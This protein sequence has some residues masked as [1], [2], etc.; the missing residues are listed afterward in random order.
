[1]TALLLGMAG[2]RAATSAHVVRGVIT[3]VRPRDIAHADSIQLR[4][5]SGQVISLKVADSVAFPPSH[6]RE[7]ML[8]AEPVT[9]TYADGPDGAVAT[10]V[11]D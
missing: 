5:E 11:T 7:H 10:E 1:V 3:D 8:F 2:C 6:L 4:T 9:V